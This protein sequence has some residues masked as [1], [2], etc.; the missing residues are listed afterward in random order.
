M[1]TEVENAFRAK[2]K[3]FYMDC[4]VKD[5]WPVFSSFSSSL[6]SLYEL[7]QKCFN[8]LVDYVEIFELLNSELQFKLLAQAPRNE[9]EVLVSDLVDIKKIELSTEEV[10]KVFKSIPRKYSFFIKLPNFNITDYSFTDLANGVSIVSIFP[11]EL[12]DEAMFSSLI[13]KRGS[14]S[15][16][17]DTGLNHGVYL[18]ISV[19]GY[20]GSARINSTV[21]KVFSILKQFLFTGIISGH[22]RIGERKSFWGINHD[23]NVH[24]IDTLFPHEVSKIE[25][26]PEDFIKLLSS[27]IVDPDHMKRCL[28][29]K[30]D[31][32]PQSILA[33]MLAGP[34]NPYL[35]NQNGL[36][37]LNSREGD[38]NTASIKNALEWGFDSYIKSSEPTM[39]FILTAV[40]LEAI[41]GDSKLKEGVTERLADRCSYLVGMNISERSIIRAKFNEFYSVR[42]KLIHGRQRRL[43]PDDSTLLLWGRNILSQ[44]LYREIFGSKKF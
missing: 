20:C 43:S 38:A 39:A 22:F 33:R 30:N 28:P 17:G 5:R 31:I 21:E 14:T 11:K 27:I 15:G 8:D 35:L 16:S 1:R 12:S 13:K 24:F 26:V 18:R 29:D 32:E 3:Q 41:L 42:S 6:Q 44:V 7:S 34:K 2:I 10:L 25:G 36:K 19:E 9:E 37:V 4:K 23:S 40:A